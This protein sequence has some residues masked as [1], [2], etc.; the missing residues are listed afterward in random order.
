MVATSPNVIDSLN[1]ILFAD[2]VTILLFPVKVLPQ[3]N[4]VLSCSN[5]SW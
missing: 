4:A 3:Y 2:T 1:E 5:N